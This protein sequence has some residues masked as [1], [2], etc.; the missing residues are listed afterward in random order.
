MSTGVSIG[1]I[2]QLVTCKVKKNRWM[3]AS[4]CVQVL[5]GF[6]LDWQVVE[7]RRRW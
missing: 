7:I 1:N 4:G 6:P 5:Y 2:F 3:M